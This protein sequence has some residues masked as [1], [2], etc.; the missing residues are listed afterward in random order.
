MKR[1]SFTII[2]IIF[3][4]SAI[5]LVFSLPLCGHGGFKLGPA[6]HS[7]GMQS[8]GGNIYD[9]HITFLQTIFLAKLEWL[10]FFV[11]ALFSSL[12]VA[13][14]FSPIYNAITIYIKDKLKLYFY[15][16]SKPFDCLAPAYCRG[17]I[18]QR[19]LE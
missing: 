17:R 12:V 14:V 15:K 6:V 3:I 5:L 1:K 9:S 19:L 16:L 11:L 13:V 4:V 10:I 18:Y 2:S 8:C 7:S